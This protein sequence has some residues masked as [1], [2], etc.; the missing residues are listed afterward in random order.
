LVASPEGLATVVSAYR[1]TPDDV[2]R[3]PAAEVL[4]ERLD[5]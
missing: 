5:R 4:D 1:F 2:I 3:G